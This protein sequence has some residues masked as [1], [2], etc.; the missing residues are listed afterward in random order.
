MPDTS[1]T[2]ETIDTIDEPEAEPTYSTGAAG[3]LARQ[4]D[5]LLAQASQN[6]GM[7]EIYAEK[8]RSARDRAAQ[9]QAAIEAIP[10]D[11]S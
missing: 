10:A 2:I 11:P 7:A 6:D 3:E 9:L 1:S 4:R 8:A 5:V